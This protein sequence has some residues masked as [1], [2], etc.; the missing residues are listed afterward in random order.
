MGMLPMYVK[1]KVRLINQGFVRWK[2][3]SILIECDDQKFLTDE[4]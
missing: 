4:K 1:G 2:F 3:E